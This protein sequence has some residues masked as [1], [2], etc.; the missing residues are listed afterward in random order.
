[1]SVP[2]KKRIYFDFQL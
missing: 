2:Y 1:L